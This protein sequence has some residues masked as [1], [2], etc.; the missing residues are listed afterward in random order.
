MKRSQ[1]S[2]KIAPLALMAMTISTST[3]A[4]VML[5]NAPA[6][7]QFILGQPRNV[8]IPRGVTIPLTSEKERIGVS[9]DS[10]TK[11]T[12]T[13][14]T[15]IIDGN[16]NVLI[17]RGSKINGELQPV[18]FDGEK[19]VQFVATELVFPNGTK[20]FIDAV[21]PVITRKEKIKKG[22]STG[23]VLTNAG[24]GAAGATAIA[25]ITGNRRVEILE[26]IIGAAAGAGGTLILGGSQKEVVVINPRQQELNVTLRSNLLISRNS[27][28]SRF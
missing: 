9:P 1:P 20:Q 19:G 25:L 8:S 28:T 6:N 7:A 17:P 15:N 22:P 13:V 10:P 24:I 5:S 21:S 23:Q 4:P 16:R 12:L 18:N 26:P 3:I 11:L 27:S 14:A 2:W